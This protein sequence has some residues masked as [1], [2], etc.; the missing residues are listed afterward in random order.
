MMR[1]KLAFPSPKGH[2][3]TRRDVRPGGFHTTKEVLFR[4][5]LR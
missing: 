4:E 3:G 1:T 5:H 2:E